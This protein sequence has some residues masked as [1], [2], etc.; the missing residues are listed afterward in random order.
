MNAYLDAI[1]PVLMFVILN[2]CVA[3]AGYR[4][5][6]SLVGASPVVDR[7][8]TFLALG[9]L[10]SL[11]LMLIGG[12]LGLIGL[13]FLA[14]SSVV[15]GIV[16]GI[17]TR[18]AR[19]SLT[20]A[21]AA[22]SALT[23]K[24]RENP[25]FFAPLA[26]PAVLLLLTYAWSI[27]R[28]PSGFD[29]LNYHLVLASHF[30]TSNGI[31]VFD[32][33]AWFE[34]FGYFPANAEL[35]SAWAWSVGGNG[36]FLTLVN[37]PFVLLLV[38]SVY[39]LARLSGVSDTPASALGAASVLFPMIFRAVPEAYV[40]LPLWGTFFAGLTFAILAGRAQRLDLF[41][42]SM[43]LAGTGVGIKATGIVQF[44]IIAIAFIASVNKFSRRFTFFAVVTAFFVVTLFGSAFYI[45]NLAVTGN[46][47]FPFPVE[48]FGIEIFPGLADHAQMVSQTTISRFFLPML[49]DGSLLEALLGVTSGPNAGWGFG[50][51]GVFF[52]LSGPL[53][54]IGLIA[55]RFG[56]PQSRTIGLV[57][58][59]SGLLVTLSY[60]HLPW[61]APFLQGNVR[62]L[63]PAVI[64]FAI[65]VVIFAKSI[66]ISD[67]SITSAII[68]LSGISIFFGVIPTDAE[69]TALVGGGAALLFF[70]AVLS[71]AISPSQS[72]PVSKTRKVMGLAVVSL[73]LALF[74]AHLVVERANPGRAYSQTT[75]SHGPFEWSRGYGPCVQAVNS[76]ADNATVAVLAPQRVPAGLFLSPITGPNGRR[77][78]VADNSR[79]GY[80]AG[81]IPKAADA[82]VVLFGP[83]LDRPAHFDLNDSNGKRT[84]KIFE[85]EHCAV[86]STTDASVIK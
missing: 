55:R 6:N 35:W 69:V 8:I 78:I 64:L 44:A 23:T 53:A 43:A 52:L 16:V 38:L 22:H 68:L 74:L 63:Y 84:V 86:F 36:L 47:I 80:S 24:F 27:T 58:A 26:M 49:M 29:P 4:L 72:G 75:F 59:L 25:W 21:D 60:I 76:L 11:A 3:F 73:M 85:D 56:S 66:V 54:A 20:L 79:N 32:F 18:R 83:S 51:I 34:Y 48:I 67:V 40:E 33:P 14:T 1:Q 9:S 12:V 57:F 46:P 5:S 17:L 65:T 7:I 70:V 82:L 77:R 81:Q 19:V 13:P 71:R 10:F 62:F 28:P 42:I 15:L 39:R 2:G 61:C 31:Q 30:L 50:P 45:R 37:V 41:A